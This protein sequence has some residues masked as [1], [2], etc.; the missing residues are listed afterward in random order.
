MFF[1]LK[2]SKK[3]LEILHTC[4]IRKLYIRANKNLKSGYSYYY[5]IIRL[6]VLPL[7]N[8]KT[9]DDDMRIPCT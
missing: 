1:N 2:K 5:I 4:R 7:T 3:M 8:I 6:P 9:L